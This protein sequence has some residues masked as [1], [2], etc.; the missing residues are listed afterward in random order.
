MNSISVV[1]GAMAKTSRGTRP[2]SKQ[3]DVIAMLRSSKGATIAAIV[4]K[5][6]W[7]PHSVR[8]FFSGVVR[9]KLRLGLTS[10]KTDGGRVY[11][12]TK[13]HRPGAANAKRGSR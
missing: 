9:K 4:K 5:T 3:S 2:D 13:R 7:Q 12:I 1:R 8:G 6:D 11:R 10:E